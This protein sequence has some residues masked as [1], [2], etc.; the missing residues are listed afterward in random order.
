MLY[1]ATFRAEI[2]KNGVSSFFSSTVLSFLLS[3]YL[4]SLSVCVCSFPITPSVSKKEFNML[5]QERSCS[6]RCRCT[7]CLH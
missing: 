3:F 4:S 2:K 5:R 6:M 1:D 7:T